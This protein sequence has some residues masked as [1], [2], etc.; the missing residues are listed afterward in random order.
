MSVG[1][2]GIE[3]DFNTAKSNLII[4][5]NGSSKSSVLDAICYSLFGKAHRNINKAQLI[6]SVNGKNCHVEIE[7]SIGS[8]KYKIIRGMKPGIFEIYQNGNLMNKNSDIRDYQKILEQQILKLNYKT[9]T[10]VVILGS[11]S[12]TPFMQ[13]SPGGRREVI[14]DILDIGVFSIMNTLNKERSNL[15]K[16]EM[17]KVE[18]D[19]NTTMTLLETQKG[20]IKNLTELHQTQI[21][22]IHEKISK[23]NGD[24]VQLTDQLSTASDELMTLQNS[25]SDIGAITKLIEECSREIYRRENSQTIFNDKLEFFRM[26]SKC[27][28]CD[29]DIPHEHKENIVS[30]IQET[31]KKITKESKKI[32]E[33]LDELTSRKNEIENI[34]RQIQ[35]KKIAMSAI[36][37][38]IDSIKTNIGILKSDLTKISNR[39]SSIELEK[40]KK[41]ELAQKG[42]ELTTRRKALIE[43]K[44]LELTAQTLLKDNGIKTSIIREYLP[45]MN[46]TINK[47]LEMMDF[48]VK[49]ELDEGFNETIKSRYRDEFTYASFSEGEKQKIDISLLFAWRHIAKLKNSVNTNILFLDEV[50]NSNL[51]SGSVELLLAMLDDMKHD[52]NIFVITHNTENIID[53]FDRVIKFEKVGNFS[54][55]TEF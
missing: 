50:L 41:K 54:T 49:F 39:T 28:S 30:A 40:N 10:Q 8:V 7:F 27:D 22:D 26:N 35:A 55:I 37:S 17:S 25:I 18:N 46:M 52:S 3:F 34:N 44:N 11:A 24:M 12:F 1:N 45:I 6:N 33:K 48:F 13:L 23:N 38:S 15:T 14:E 42:L 32:S 21:D 19:L 4:G 29:Q 53:R 20:V 43:Q 16:E 51:D 36:K 31:V 9:F 47:Y 2:S 5:K